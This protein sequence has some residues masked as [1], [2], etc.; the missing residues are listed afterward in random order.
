MHLACLHACVVLLFASAAAT[1]SSGSLP[2]SWHQVRPTADM[3]PITQPSRLGCR[4]GHA[5][6]PVSA[7]CLWCTCVASVHRQTL[8]TEPLTN[9]AAYNICVVSISV[10]Q[11]LAWC[12]GLVDLCWSSWKQVC[13]HVCVCVLTPIPAGFG[14]TFMSMAFEDPCYVY[15]GASGAVFGF[16]GE[17]HM[18]VKPRNTD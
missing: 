1:G 4:T 12:R 3:L 7:P 5:G 13:I 16:I 18:P 14:G 2:S 17:C 9:A 10:L 6:Q 15:V 11:A 8:L